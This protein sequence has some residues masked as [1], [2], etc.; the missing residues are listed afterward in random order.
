M[1]WFASRSRRKNSVGTVPSPPEQ[2]SVGRARD[3]AD[4]WPQPRHT[5]GS[6]DRRQ[7]VA[8]RHRGK[9][10]SAPDA[11][12][13]RG[14][15]PPRALWGATG[16]RLWPP[17]P[18][19][20]FATRLQDPA[21]DPRPPAACASMALPGNCGPA[22]C[23]TRRRHPAPQLGRARGPAPHTPTTRWP[24]PAALSLPW[25]RTCP[26]VLQAMSTG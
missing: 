22:P 6:Q 10:V 16:L 20:S 5:V 17:K 3:L 8:R 11:R 15:V 4:M 24:P 7:A 14:G 9:G 23:R 1:S 21:M 26:A 25:F 19:P 18:H 2:R 13:G 12:Q